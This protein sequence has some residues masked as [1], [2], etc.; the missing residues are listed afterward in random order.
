MEVEAGVL[1][2]VVAQFRDV[3]AIL[4]GVDFAQAVVE[5]ALAKGGEVAFSGANGPR[6]WHA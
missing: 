5:N 2:D 6:G 4:S 3:K 1:H